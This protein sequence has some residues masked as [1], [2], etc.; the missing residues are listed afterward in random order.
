MTRS[1]VISGAATAAAASLLA[2][3]AAS[4]GNKCC[5]LINLDFKAG[6]GESPG[7]A[8]CAPPPAGTQKLSYVRLVGVKCGEKPPTISGYTVEYVI[9][10]AGITG[11]D[12]ENT[13]HGSTT[14]VDGHKNMK[15]NV[16]VYVKT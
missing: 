13:Q 14:T 3:T 10:D 11:R 6:G 8:S 9:A 16:F 5:N 4:A 15:Q 12:E 1:A 2:P 7:A